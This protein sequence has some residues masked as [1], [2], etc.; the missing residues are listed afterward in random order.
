MR[1]ISINLSYFLLLHQ[2]I[3]ETTLR[4]KART[5]SVGNDG[6][7]CKRQQCMEL[8][9]NIS[10]LYAEDKKQMLRRSFTEYGK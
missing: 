7:S 1:I 8:L 3:T 2:R 5:F 6:Y 10:I 4:Y 9:L